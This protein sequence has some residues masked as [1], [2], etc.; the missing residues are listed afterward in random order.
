MNSDL[1]GYGFYE[2]QT[3]YAHID[4]IIPEDSSA[5]ITIHKRILADGKESEDL[6]QFKWRLLSDQL[7]K[8]TMDLMRAKRKIKHLLRIDYEGQRG[9]GKYNQ[10]H[11]FKI[12]Y[13]Y[14]FGTMEC[15]I[16]ISVD[17]RHVI[18]NG[19]QSK[20]SFVVNHDGSFGSYGT[21][22]KAVLVRDCLDKLGWP[23]EL[24]ASNLSQAEN[25]ALFHKIVNLTDEVDELI[26]Q[27]E[28]NGIFSQSSQQQEPIDLGYE[29]LEFEEINNDGV[30]VIDKESYDFFKLRMNHAIGELSAWLDFLENNMNGDCDGDC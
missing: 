11:Q 14:Q 6:G 20:N 4:E 25:K 12:N 30:L 28:S 17:L 15:L 26:S 10:M 2:P 29:D 8:Q 13:V 18:V 19:S 21:W 5:I 23:E 1:K 3:I 9:H 22:Q 27:L 7:K 16:P 24:K